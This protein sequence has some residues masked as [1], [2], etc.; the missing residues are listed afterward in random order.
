M[1]TRAAGPAQL[2]RTATTN[3]TPIP[4]PLGR[5]VSWPAYAF[6]AATA[7]YVAALLLNAMAGMPMPPIVATRVVASLSVLAGAPALVWFVILIARPR[8]SRHP[9]A[10]RVAL[11]AVAVFA[12][13]AITNRVLQLAIAAQL[14]S[15]PDLYV[16]PSPANFAEMFAW[17]LCLG[18]LAMALS[19]LLT[20]TAQTSSRHTFMIAGLLLLSGELTFLMSVANLGGLPI[21][22]TG[23]VF[24]VAAWVVA[25]PTA[26]FLTT[27]AARHVEV[28]RSKSE[29]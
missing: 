28:G 15:E 21:A 14:V 24:S 1:S 22:M 29:P 3:G 20:E 17:D 27:F 9:V 2:A 10:A 19:L 4:R 11:T 8:S 7:V 23:M 16:V 25:F 12:V 18:V 26:V 5:S 13:V 6:L